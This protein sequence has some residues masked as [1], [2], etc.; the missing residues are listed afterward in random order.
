M[1]KWDRE[2]ERR[3][4]ARVMGRPEWDVGELTAQAIQRS[5]AYERLSRVTPGSRGKLLEELARQERENVQTLRRLGGK[6]PLRVK[7]WPKEPPRA[8]LERCS[9][10]ARQ[11]RDAYEQL[12][13]GSARFLPLA[14]CQQ[15]HCVTLTQLLEGM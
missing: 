9:R 15:T 2:M 11:A 5:N 12:S 14:A 1:E 6:S 3:V 13:T 8:L 7:P 10:S 4:W